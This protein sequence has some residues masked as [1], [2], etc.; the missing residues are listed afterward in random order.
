[1]SGKV[2]ENEFQYYIFDALCADCPIIVSV[3]TFS[4]GDPDLYIK[5]GD[6]QLPTT[7]SYDVLSTTFMSELLR[8][9]LE[10]P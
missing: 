7:T 1:M 5:F 9:D 6:T 4:T 10:D 3:S 8:I 2:D